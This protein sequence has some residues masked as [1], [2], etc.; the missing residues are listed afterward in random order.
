MTL[1]FLTR[2]V[3]PGLA[4]GILLGLLSVAVLQPHQAQ[5]A[6]TAEQ[7][8]QALALQAEIRKAGS[9]YKE[10]KFQESA[11]LLAKVQEKA[12]ALAQQTGPDAQRLLKAVY[13]SLEKAHALLEVEG[14]SLPPIVRPGGEGAA[15]GGVSFKT[16]VAPVLVSRCGAC[17]VNNARGMFSM[18][19][20]SALMKG[21][22]AGVVVFAGDAVGS[23]LIEVIESGDMPR[24]GGKVAAE[25]L[26][27]LKKWIVEGARFD[28]DDPEQ[29]LA[30]LA[31]ESRPSEAPKLELVQATGKETISFARDLAPV[32]AAN[33]A[34]CHG[35][36]NNPG[37]RLNLTT[38]TTLLN[39]GDSGAVLAPGSPEE[40]LLIRKLKGTAGGQRMPLRQPP[41][42]DDVIARFE[43]WIREGAAFDG[44]DPAQHVE[45]VAAIAKANAASHEEL[46]ADRA[47][48]SLANWR[49]G[50]PQAA[51]AQAQTENFLMLGNVAQDV[52]ANYGQAAEAIAP[53][54]AALLKAPAGK[55]LIKGRLTVFV[56][57][58]RYDYSEFGQMVEK[59]ALPKEWAGHWRY[60]IVD[61]YGAMLA[62]QRESYSAETLV[63]QQLAGVYVASLGA[64]TPSWFAEG[65]ARAVA[66]R[67]NGSDPR[68]LSW[69]EQLPAVL[70]SMS[71]PDDFLT[72][73][74][75]PESAD[76]ASYSFVDFLMR[77]GREY[78][79]LLERLRK[80]EEFAQ[81]FPA[82]FKATP[83]Q[84]T[85]AW[86][87]SAAKR[88]APVRPRR[89]AGKPEAVEKAGD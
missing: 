6:P 43:T 26:E 67:L 88:R 21:P 50:M 82:V 41:L 33:C 38:F 83:S 14:V 79:A 49:L 18:A 77:S 53:K 12:A 32:L 81:A 60:N 24:G 5:A 72:G 34:G 8:K 48:R 64:K 9:L 1:S 2:T 58:T 89:P 74:L 52:L 45:Q 85:L 57:Q 16:Q 7:R 76:I 27:L 56:F 29:R 55:P 87:Q 61:A 11:E 30:N 31:P 84:L 59:R 13:D 47:A 62:P 3:S 4:L 51:P 20:F 70:A 36:A 22:P 40:S 78:N 86:A 35:N 39:G 23:R 63:G 69:N 44:P 37:G 71:A 28:G 15:A 80:G 17:H 46:S 68:V 19:S 75:S 10:G 66:A 42:A 65:S 25:E 73:K 54:V